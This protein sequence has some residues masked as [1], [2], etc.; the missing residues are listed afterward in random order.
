MCRQRPE[1][2]QRLT[3]WIVEPSERHQQWQQKA[4]ADFVPSVRWAKGLPELA[5]PPPVSDPRHAS[6]AAR[7]DVR[8]RRIIFANELLDAFPAHRL[9]WDAKGQRWFE[10][11]VT[12]QEGRFVWT[13]LSEDASGLMLRSFPPQLVA[14]LGTVLPDGFIVEVCPAAEHWWRAAASVLGRGKLL[15]MDYGLAAEELL[16]PQRKR[17]TLRAYRRHQSS[18]EVLAHP[19]EQ[20]LTAHVNFSAIQA[21]GESAG[22]HTEAFL[23]QEQFLT[24]VA[25]RAWEADAS[26]GEWR[27]QDTRQFQTLTH[28]EHLGRAFRVLVQARS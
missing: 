9:G 21:A 13:R 6:L 3:Y 1:L 17:G 11:G 22:L 26:L 5:S 4:V 27:A 7:H 2:F 23:M 10:W 12:L 20:D 14:Q 25:K 15:T 16:A 19:G 24:R 8:A 28:P 18:G